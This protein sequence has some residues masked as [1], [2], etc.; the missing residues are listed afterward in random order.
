MCVMQV[1]RKTALTPY[2][3]RIGWDDIV[4]TCKSIIVSS[5]NGCHWDLR[6]RASQHLQDRSFHVSLPSFVDV[7]AGKDFKSESS[8]TGEKRPRR[9]L[10]KGE[11]TFDVGGRGRPGSGAGQRAFGEKKD[12]NDQEGNRVWSNK[13][14]SPQKND[15]EQRSRKIRVAGEWQRS[16]QSRQ[17]HRV[18]R[19]FSQRRAP[20]ADLPHDN[21]SDTGGDVDMDGSLGLPEGSTLRSKKNWSKQNKGKTQERQKGASRH[22]QSESQIKM[23]KHGFLEK[24]TSERKVVKKKEASAPVIIQVPADVS[25]VKFAKLLG[26]ASFI[27]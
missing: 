2:G 7:A 4:D 25:V 14:N 15:P 23:S 26:T 3:R 18:P 6:S 16:S 21:I 24:K 1:V 12:R 8:S 13:W 10:K 20:V 9:K 5:I 17:G 19:D 11:S 22:S 27:K